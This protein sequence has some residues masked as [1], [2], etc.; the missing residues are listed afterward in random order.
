MVALIYDP[1]FLEHDTGTHHPESADR[2]R[3]ILMH[4]EPLRNRLLW[5]EPV[6]AGYNTLLS[7]HTEA[8]IALVEEAS[9]VA[10]AI[11]A[12]TQTSLHSYEAALKAAG[13]GIV[14]VDAIASGRASSAFAAVR[15]PGHHA[16]AE[17]AMGFCLF[18]NIAV[19]A[20]YAQECGYEKVFI[21]DFDVHHG[22]GTQAIFYDDPTVFYFSS[23]QYPAYPGSGD[24]VEEGIGGGEGFT[25]NFPLLPESGD[26][27]I[28]PIYE[29]ELPKAVA[30]FGPDIILVSAGYDLHESDPL[31]SLYISTEA[32]RDI[33]QS[34]MECLDV[35]KIFF[36]EGGYNLE[37][38][39]ECVKATLEVMLASE[40]SAS[41]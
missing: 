23:H 26:E 33:V 7:V 37:A 12:D 3:S 40:G 21:V 14:A 25:M 28:L 19:A 1:L 15:P 29:E 34:I 17:R 18:N 30:A 24:S 41:D 6:S 38:L 39:G 4:L 27:T 13:S 5:L 32:I 10:A 2:L 20:R 36:L 8:H 22:N 9:A 31:A 11:D 35:P 16:T